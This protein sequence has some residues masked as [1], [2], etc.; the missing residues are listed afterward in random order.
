L[1]GRN[2][3]PQLPLS[4]A[5]QQKAAMRLAAGRRQAL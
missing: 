1:P 5:K 3:A 2:A 4:G